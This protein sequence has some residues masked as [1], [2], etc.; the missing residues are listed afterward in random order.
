MNPFES[1]ATALWPDIQ[2]W[3]VLKHQPEI[4]SLYRDL[5]KKYLIE[6][7]GALDDKA[8]DKIIK[9]LIKNIIS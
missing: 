1:T 7:F 9:H 3:L 2:D 6:K 8:R 5:F 4:E